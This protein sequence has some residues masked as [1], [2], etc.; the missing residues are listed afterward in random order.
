MYTQ[1]LAGWREGHFLAPTFWDHHLIRSRRFG[2]VLRDLDYSLQTAGTATAMLEGSY[3]GPGPRPLSAWLTLLGSLQYADHVVRKTGNHLEFESAIWASAFTLSLPIYSTSSTLIVNGLKAPA[4]EEGEQQHATTNGGGSSGEEGAKGGGGE[5]GDLRDVSVHQ[6]TRLHAYN[7][8]CK[9]AANGI[10]V[11]LQKT[12][13]A[14]GLFQLSAQRYEEAGTGLVKVRYGVSFKVHEHPVSFHLP[15][16]RFL[17]ASVLEGVQQGLGLPNLELE[18]EPSPFATLLAEFPL[19]CMAL[20]AQVTAGLWRRNGMSIQ[21]QVRRR[22][23]SWVHTCRRMSKQAK[24]YPSS[25]A[26]LTPYLI[27]SPLSFLLVPA[28]N[29]RPCT[30]L[31][32]PFA[33]SFGT[34]I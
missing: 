14:S 23:F 25:R 7:N 19:R 3:P 15:L 34:S 24:V 10:A 1:R 32:H 31:L 28:S 16:H 20:N 2:H 12:G 29:N 18:G 21:G 4:D 27:S 33:R 26:C 6:A 11:W 8:L 5:R 30:T 9:A 22:K 17:A 13:Q